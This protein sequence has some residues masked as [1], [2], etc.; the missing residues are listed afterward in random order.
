MKY[1]C[2]LLE[3]LKGEAPHSRIDRDSLKRTLPAGK[4]DFEICALFIQSTSTNPQI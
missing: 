3:S 1:Y 2:P 4:Y